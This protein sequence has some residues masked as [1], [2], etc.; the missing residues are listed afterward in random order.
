MN[1]LGKNTLPGMSAVEDQE[2]REYRKIFNAGDIYDGIRIAV[3]TLDVENAGKTHILRPGLVL[4]R[5]EAGGSAG[6]YV[7]A[8]H[9]SVPAHADIKD[10]VVLNEFVNMNETGASAEKLAHGLVHGVV[11]ESLLLWGTADADDKA[12]MKAALKAGGIIFK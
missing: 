3:D 10:C 5:V 4:I 1:N 9:A 7:H 6:K 8:T 11:S 2:S 12:A